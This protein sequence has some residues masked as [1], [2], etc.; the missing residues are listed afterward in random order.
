MS[1]FVTKPFVPPLE[2]YIAE[3]EKIWRDRV[4]TNQGRCVTSLE[5]VIR[6]YLQCQNFQL[7]S[8]G[9][10]ALQLAIDA[11]NIK[12]GEIITTPFTY[13]ATITSIL[14]QRCTPVFADIELNNFTINPEEVEALISSHTKA[15][16]PVHVFGYACKVDE[17]EK[18]SKN[19]N[20]PLIYDAAHAFGS[21][22]KG[23]SLLT[24]GDLSTVS[25]HATKLYHMAEGG[26]ISVNSTQLSSRVDLLKRFGHHYDEYICPG[27][28]AKISEIQAALGLVNFKYLNSIISER[29][30][31]S[32]KYDYL[33]DNVISRPAA[34]EGLDYN[35]AYYP[36]VF[37]NEAELLKVIDTL[38]K[39]DIY[40]RRYFYPS[41]NTL[42]YVEKR[43]C[44]I[45]ES[46]S[47]RILCIPLYIG[48]EDD[49][50]EKIALLIKKT[51]G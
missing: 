34:Q 2:E 21:K 44:P 29:K 51:V 46:L 6:E 12:E 27:I 39:C 16:M 41:L 48:L 9:T 38:N 35:Y 10:I 8:N 43:S 15:I 37:D 7:V 26:G 18:I 4:F 20:V 42:P 3:L 11:L 47:K 33:L 14:W 40:P 45:S 17:L 28:N 49:Y 13:V 25:F 24:F 22:Y 1:V 50:I 36:V 30:S 5:K 32:M 31:I 19:Y 23:Q